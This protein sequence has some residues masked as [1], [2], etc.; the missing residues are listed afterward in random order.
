MQLN[1]MLNNNNKKLLPFWVGDNSVAGVKQSDAAAKNS[2][3][4]INVAMF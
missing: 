2:T 3:R 1:K 4:M